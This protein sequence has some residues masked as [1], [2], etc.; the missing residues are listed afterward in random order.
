MKR[1]VEVEKRFKTIPFSASGNLFYRK[2]L[3]ESQSFVPNPG[4]SDQ[5]VLGP[6]VQYACPSDVHRGPCMYRT[7]HI[8]AYNTLIKDQGKPISRVWRLLQNVK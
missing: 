8:L 3:G 2:D 6:T 5:I 1:I 7:W 4:Q